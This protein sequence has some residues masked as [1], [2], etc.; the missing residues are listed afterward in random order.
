L[1]SFLSSGQLPSSEDSGHHRPNQHASEAPQIEEA[2]NALDNEP[3]SWTPYIAR[4]IYPHLP[5]YA[6]PFTCSV[7]LTRIR[8]IAH[9]NYIPSDVKMYIKHNLQ[10]K[11][12]RCA[13]PEDAKTC[14]RILDQIGHG[15]YS[16]YFVHQLH[17]AALAHRGQE[18]GDQGPH[19]RV[20]AL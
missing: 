7:P 2:L 9:R 12:H 16:L 15:G 3:D 18:P 5:S 20:R 11:L 8:D 6:S 14:E 1:L 17:A 19:G 13:G 10:N 4:S